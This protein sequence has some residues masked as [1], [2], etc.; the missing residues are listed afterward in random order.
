MPDGVIGNTSDS[1]SEESRF[2]TW[3]GNK[4]STLVGAFLFEQVEKPVPMR[5][6]I[7]ETWSGN[8]ASTL[9]GALLFEQ[10]EKFIPMSLGIG[11][12]CQGRENKLSRLYTLYNSGK[13]NYLCDSG[14]NV[15]LL[16]I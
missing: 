10:V 11:K 16:S 3:S 9:V 12:R 1:G 15:L 6:R 14:E 13:R 5:L 8:K 7:G 4:A 2:E